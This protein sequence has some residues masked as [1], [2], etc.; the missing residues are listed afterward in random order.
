VGSR[1]RATLSQYDFERLISLAK[2]YRF[3]T[4]HGIASDSMLAVVV[5]LCETVLRKIFA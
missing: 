3:L 4:R 5:L 1:H 2:L